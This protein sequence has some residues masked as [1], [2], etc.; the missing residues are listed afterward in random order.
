MELRKE[1]EEEETINSAKKGGR[2]RLNE[3]EKFK[4]E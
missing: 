3:V 1:G 2:K 4:Q